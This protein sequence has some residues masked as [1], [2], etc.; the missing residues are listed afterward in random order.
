MEPED[1]ILIKI[2]A[3]YILLWCPYLAF[4]AWF[5]ENKLNSKKNPSWFKNKRLR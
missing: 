2:L 3:W 4:L 5:C 1:I